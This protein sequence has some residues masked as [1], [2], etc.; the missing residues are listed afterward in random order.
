MISSQDLAQDVK[1]IIATFGG[2]ISAQ[3]LLE[4][5]TERIENK[6]P[7]E[8]IQELPISDSISGLL[9]DGY[10]KMT[11]ADKADLESDD[12]NKFYYVSQDYINED[13]YAI[14]EMARAQFE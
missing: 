10:L 9:T 3:A 7:D 13:W 11:V 2:Y 4:V 14:R 8:D 6:Y 12:P 1:S 5:L